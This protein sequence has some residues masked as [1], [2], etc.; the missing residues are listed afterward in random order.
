MDVVPE[1]LARNAV[2]AWGETGRRFLENLPEQLDEV[3]RAWRLTVEK[4]YAMSFH[5]VCRART[6]DGVEAVLKLAPP[7]SRDL[8]RETATL[9]H[10]DGRG[11]VRVL[12]H[13]APS[14]A[15]LLERAEPG[16]LA[17]EAP[18]I[19]ATAAIITVIHR[20]HHNAG[21]EPGLPRLLERDERSFV[22]HLRRYPDGA[23]SQSTV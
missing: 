5:W 4:P 8:A 20:L 10:Y 19:V 22:D 3:A 6:A 18:D 14:G 21:D 12:A 23:P 13:A 1:A 17:R 9:L 7:G 11:A 16:T 2:A 15:L